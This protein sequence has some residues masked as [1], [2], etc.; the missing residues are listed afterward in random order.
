MLLKYT[1]IFLDPFLIFI[2]FI[3]GFILYCTKF[4]KKRWL[5]LT[6]V[7][8]SISI[9][10]V[11]TGI[12]AYWLYYRLAHIYPVVMR[13]DHQI[14]WVVVL[15]GGHINVHDA[16]INQTLNNVTI[17][18]FLEGVRIYKALP[19]AKLIL[20]GGYFLATTLADTDAAQMGELAKLLNI[21]SDSI[22]LEQSSYNTAD[23]AKEIKKLVKNDYFYLVTSAIHMPRSMFLFQS[24]GLHPIAAPADYPYKSDKFVDLLKVNPSNWQ[25]LNSTLHEYLGIL[26]ARL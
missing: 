12:I 2:F 9:F 3:C 26:W 14:K 23:E 16:P 11:N 18:R 24:M 1:E 25:V 5:R 8:L 13:P 15:G 20:S 21:S 19:D 7:F 4:T 22:I 6:F 17:R 10:F